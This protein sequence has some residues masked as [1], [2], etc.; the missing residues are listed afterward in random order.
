MHDNLNK[1][2]V[3]STLPTPTGANGGPV[4]F[5]ATGDKFILTPVAPIE[6]VRFG[7][8]TDAAMDPDAGGFV[9]AL[10]HRPTAG[11]D[12]G[13]TESATLTRTDT[14]TVA[15]G[16]LVYREVV[17][18]DTDGETAEDGETRYVAPSGPLSVDVGEQAVLEVT[19]AVGAAST[20][21]VFIEY[22]QK[23]FD[24]Y[25]SVVTEATS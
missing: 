1:V 12:T 3:V 21:Y 16:S 11:S 20:G 13:R 6:I 14:Q 10:D 5:N 18:A 4:D 9:L 2:F 7:F 8:V 25:D 24:L 17:L 23:P 19:N 22:V 15:A